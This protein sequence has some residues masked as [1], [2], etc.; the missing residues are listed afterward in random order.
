MYKKISQT[1]FTLV[2]L[3]VVTTLVAVLVM[4]AVPGFRSFLLKRAVL[5]AVDAMMTDLRYARSEAIK[6]S[7]RVTLCQSASGTNCSGADGAWVN[8]WMVFIDANGDG[9]F[10]AGEQILRVQQALPSITSIARPAGSTRRFFTYQA[11][12]WAK[13]ADETLVFVPTGPAPDAER[14]VCISNQGRPALKAAGAAS[15]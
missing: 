1:G 7:T 13:S 4:L 15:C 6:R 10:D 2:E 14:L 5:S 11:T 12:G 3:M 8:G 9:T